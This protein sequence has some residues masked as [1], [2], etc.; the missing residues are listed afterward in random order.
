VLEAVSHALNEYRAEYGQY[1]PVSSV[2]YEYE[3][4]EEPRMPDWLN[5]SY[6]PAHPDTTNTLFHFGLLGHLM[7]RDPGNWRNPP[8]HVLRHFDCHQW[9]A[10]TKRDVEAKNR[11]A[12]FLDGIVSIWPVTNKA[13]GFPYY[14][15]YAT[16]RDA[17]ERELR[18]ESHP[19][20]QTYKL[21][22]LGADGQD[23][24]SDDIHK[25]RWDN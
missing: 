5:R 2:A 25:D 11:W 15:D 7:H 18:Y 19:P 9:I 21:W 16:F 24:T 6:F 1:P 4:A 13:A 22:S 14:N 20:Y 10:D 3:H 17:W 8:E 12:P 23:G